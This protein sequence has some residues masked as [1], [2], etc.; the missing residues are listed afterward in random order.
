MQIENH[1]QLKNLIN[2]FHLPVQLTM[3]T[4][5]TSFTALVPAAGCK[6]VIVSITGNPVDWKTPGQTGSFTISDG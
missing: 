1:G 2:S 5:N 3:V 6:L 4:S